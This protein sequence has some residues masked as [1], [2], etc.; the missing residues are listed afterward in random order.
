ML[1]SAFL[2]VSKDLN[3]VVV[4]HYDDFLALVVATAAAYFVGYSV[5]A[6]VGALNECRSVE[7]PDV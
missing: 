1:I 2:S 5:L 7:L 3:L 6:A 4:L